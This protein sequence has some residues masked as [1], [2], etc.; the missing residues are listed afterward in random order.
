MTIT[1]GRWIK[2]TLFSVAGF[3]LP[4]AVVGATGGK[5]N[6]QTFGWAILA[7]VLTAL[8]KLSSSPLEQPPPKPD[9]QPPGKE[10]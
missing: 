5:V 3:T 6:L 4:L 2:F 1:Q 10:T 7:G 8:A 9:Q